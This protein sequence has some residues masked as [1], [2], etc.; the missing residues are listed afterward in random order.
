[1]KKPPHQPHQRKVLLRIHPERSAGGDQR[2]SKLLSLKRSHQR[3]NHDV[4]SYHNC[5]IY[6]VTVQVATGYTMY[7]TLGKSH[8]FHN[9]IFAEEH[10]E[11]I[12]VEND[13][14]KRVENADEPSNSHNVNINT[15]SVKPR[16]SVDRVKSDLAGTSTENSVQIPNA[17]PQ[18]HQQIV[19]PRTSSS[20]AE[21]KET[22]VEYRVTHVQGGGDNAQ[23]AGVELRASVDGAYSLV[24]NTLK[25]STV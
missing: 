3:N 25:L 13:E 11:Q 4:F 14:N 7:T 18:K 16:P 15:P 8:T 2:N 9:K 22:Y 12:E 6:W 17:Q 21:T 5:S 23:Q 24:A 10:I 19:P 20:A 1:M